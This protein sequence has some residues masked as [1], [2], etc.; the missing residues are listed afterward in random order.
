MDNSVRG[1]GVY[2]RTPCGAFQPWCDKGRTGTGEMRSG[3]GET[4]HDERRRSAP[5]S[6]RPWGQSPSPLSALMWPAPGTT[7]RRLPQCSANSARAPGGNRDR[8][9]WPPPRSGRAAR[10]GDR[11]EA[12]QTVRG[13]GAFHVCRRHQQ[14]ARH[15]GAQRHRQRG[16][17]QAAQAVRDQQHRTAGL[18]HFA[19]TAAVHS[20]QDGC[21]QS[22]CCT[23]SRAARRP[24]SG[25]AS[26]RVRSFSIRGR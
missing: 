21:S 24:P 25:I 1:E 12:A 20:A 4:R 23:V 13:V 10:S 2:R 11:R 14:G 18:V 16:A 17:G 3:G 22:R 7:T 9:R 5:S 6:F 26:V 8:C 15:L 19:A